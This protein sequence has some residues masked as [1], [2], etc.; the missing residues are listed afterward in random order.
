MPH[1]GSNQHEI[2]GVAALRELLGTGEKVRRTV[3]WIG[4]RSG[5]EPFTDEGSVTFSDV[6]RNNPARAA[7]W[8]LYYTGE[9]L[10]GFD[11]GDLIWIVRRADESLLM[12]V[13]ESGSEWQSGCTELFGVTPEVRGGG[14][15]AGPPD[16]TERLLSF[17]AVRVATLLDLDDAAAVDASAIIDELCAGDFPTPGAMSRA[18]RE[19]AIVES[20]DPDEQL[21]MWFEQ[22]RLLFSAVERLDVARRIG[23]GFTLDDGS[24]DV[25]SFI[26][27]SLSVQNRR[28]ARAGMALENHLREIFLRHDVTFEQGARTELRSK[29]DF[30]FP[31]ADRYHDP[32]F[33]AERL[34]MLGAKTSCKE[35]WRQVLAEAQRIDR[36][37]LCTL[38][39]GI[40]S[41][42]LAEMAS[43]GLTLVV[44][45]SLHHLYPGV[46][47][48][49]L[50]TL[51]Q[52]IEEV[53][54]LQL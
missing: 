22:E 43:H 14:F 24:V 54:E 37:H 28:K 36:K 48:A 34:R 19:S 4:L 50:V 21:V 2:G 35:R 6:R 31:G 29:P 52:F 39:P 15:R 8:H 32:S 18:A 51:G 45:E 27:V 46:G 25:D 40:S 42:Q 11:E 10:R 7:E 20:D 30:L 53:R 49:A 26:R 17:A 33:P 3:T 44:P 5:C 1:L 13:A 38:D 9:F 12:V 16:V 23:D 47:R 41:H